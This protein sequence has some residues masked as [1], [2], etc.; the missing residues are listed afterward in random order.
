MDSSMYLTEDMWQC[1]PECVRN[2]KTD[3]VHS[4]PHFTVLLYHS[5]PDPPISIEPSLW[6]LQGKQSSLQTLNIRYWL[7]GGSCPMEVGNTVSL[8]PSCRSKPFQMGWLFPSP[9]FS[10]L[11][12]YISIR[13]QILCER[14][15]TIIRRAG[16]GAFN[17]L[18]EP[19][20]IVR[21]SWLLVFCSSS[22]SSWKT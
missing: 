1:G 8:H 3:L 22:I 14:V 11:L 5:G 10:I 13:I 6:F 7:H 20:L 4:E 2:W 15:G 9:L 12:P 19:I 16:V 18:L 17:L 21:T